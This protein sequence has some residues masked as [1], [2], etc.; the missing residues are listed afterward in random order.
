MHYNCSVFFTSLLKGVPLKYFHKVRRP[1][2]PIVWVIIRAARFWSLSILS[3]RP[4]SF[5]NFPKQRHSNQIEV[6]FM[7]CIS[8]EI[9]FEPGDGAA[10]NAKQS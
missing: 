5:L 9:R 3:D 6:K 1:S 8:G 10:F 7:N 4:L 2:C